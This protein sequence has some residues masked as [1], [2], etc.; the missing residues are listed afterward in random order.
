[1]KFFFYFR[2]SYTYPVL[3]S[4]LAYLNSVELQVM[5]FEAEVQVLHFKGHSFI[6]NY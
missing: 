2:H 4:Q 1:M 6:Y 5:Q 3:Q